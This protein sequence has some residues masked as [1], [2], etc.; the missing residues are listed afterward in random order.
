M[1]NTQQKQKQDLFLSRNRLPGITRRELLL[2]GVAGL[3]VG[4]SP[5]L[6]AQPSVSVPTPTATPTPVIL[7]ARAPI[8]SANAIL[9]KQ[10][11]RL[12]INSG[13]VRGLAWSADSKTLAV[14]A[15]ESV[16]IWDV[17]SAKQLATLPGQK[18]QVYQLAWSS[19][20]QLL[21]SGADD[22]TTRI[23]DVQ[24]RTAL[25]VLQ[26]PSSVILSLDW[27]SDGKRLAA[28][29]DTDTVQIWERSTWAK[30][31]QWNGPTTP[32]QYHEGSF[33]QGVYG[34]AWSPDGKQLSGVRYDGYVRVWDANSGH[35]LQTLIPDEQP[36]GVSWSPDGHI[37]ASSSDEGTVQFWDAKTFKN[38]KTLSVAGGDSV[39]WAYAIPWSPDGSLLAS[40]RSS[41]IIQVWEAASGKELVVLRGHTDSSWTAAWSPDNLRIASGSDDG[42]VC[43]WGIS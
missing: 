27:S 26:G 21:A 8:S 17:A 39:G 15:M 28:G 25:H 38:T 3:V 24:N 42:T 11:A 12:N 22:N 10:L 13:Q 6:S 20:G 34:V 40:S 33:R 14:G 30:A 32:G 23:W 31:A 1:Q 41:G 2:M 7:Q 18:G 36:N 43:L 37:L 4:C 19:D 9:L 16:Q 5:P 29:S 35:L